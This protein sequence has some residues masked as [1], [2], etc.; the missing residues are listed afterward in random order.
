[1]YVT[2]DTA[3]PEIVGRLIKDRRAFPATLM[4]IPKRSV[5]ACSGVHGV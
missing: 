1:M 3:E 2:P 4:S 5:R